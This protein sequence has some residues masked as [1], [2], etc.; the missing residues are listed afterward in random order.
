MS[1]IYRNNYFDAFL[2]PWVNMFAFVDFVK[3]NCIF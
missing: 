1:F 3:Q 2:V